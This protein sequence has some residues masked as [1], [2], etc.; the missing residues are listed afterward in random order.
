VG[1]EQEFQ[2]IEITEHEYYNHNFF[3]L[4]SSIFQCQS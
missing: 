2:N 4:I 3:W 1:G